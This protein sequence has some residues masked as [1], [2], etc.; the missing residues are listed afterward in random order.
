MVSTASF[1]WEAL[2]PLVFFMI[3][4]LVQVFGRGKK[5]EEQPELE[6]DA[7]DAAA[8][9]ARQIREEIRRRIEGRSSESDA[10]QAA[11]SARGY[12]PN[13]PESQ[14]RRPSAAAPVP[15]QSAAPRAE[16]TAR[17][18]APAGNAW[19]SSSSPVDSLQDRLREQQ[20]K[21]AEAQRAQQEAKDR[22]LDMLRQARAKQQRPRHAKKAAQQVPALD[23]LAATFR[24][25]IRAGLSSPKALRKAV[26][27]RE[28]LDKPVGLR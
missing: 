11:D 9:R 22:A 28:I 27:Y 14:Q 8:E 21:L 7:E 20:K 26:V 12:N 2:L 13:L 25:A 10:P 4:A 6:D 15:A 16:S 1:E 19:S 5:P 24:D 3:Y 18:P 17:T 23:P